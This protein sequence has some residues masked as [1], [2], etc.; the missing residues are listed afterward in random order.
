M[1]DERIIDVRAEPLAPERPE[2]FTRDHTVEGPGAWRVR[3]GRPTAP[4]VAP[5]ELHR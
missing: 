2:A 1:T 4:A 3:I 5:R